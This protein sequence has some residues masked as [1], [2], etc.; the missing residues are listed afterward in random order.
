MGSKKKEEKVAA[1][2]K[3]AER[4]K[5]K[6]KTVKKSTFIID[7][8]QPV[9]DDIFDMASFGTF[10]K[11]SIKVNGKKGQLG[12]DVKVSRTSSK[13]TVTARIEFSKRYLKYLTKKFLK[14]QS[15]RD[16]IRVIATDKQTYYLR[17]FNINQEGG[18]DDDE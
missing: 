3:V 14:K 18:D 11:D 9:D 12:D 17:Y 7:C 4:K 2:D 5:K 6:K 8:S 10:L 1:T 16:Y 15:L 13:I